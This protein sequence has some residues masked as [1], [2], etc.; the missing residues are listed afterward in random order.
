MISQRSSHSYSGS[1]SAASLRASASTS[2][3]S[4]SPTAGEALSGARD[5]MAELRKVFRWREEP[6]S[7]CGLGVAR[8]NRPSGVGER[9][10]PGQAFKRSLA[11]ATAHTA[12][13]YTV[14]R[15]TRE[16][17]A[18][19]VRDV[20]KHSDVECRDRA[21]RRSRPRSR[22]V[23][24]FLGGAPQC[25]TIFDRTCTRRA[26]SRQLATPSKCKNP[27][28]FFILTALDARIVSRE[29]LRRSLTHRTRHLQGHGEH[30]PQSGSRWIAHARPLPPNR[31]L[32]PTSSTRLVA[33]DTAYGPEPAPE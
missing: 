14:C 15:R 10:G 3:I 31:R 28:L 16:P 4:S 29:A 18:C 19:T 21:K 1:N 7:R 25:R 33:T 23:P 22:S 2:R 27:R 5:A 9:E 30:P 32:P 26:A 8:A 20:N 17:L 13:N 11:C 6:V 24:D 12:P